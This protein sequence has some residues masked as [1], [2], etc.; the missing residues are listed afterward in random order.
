MNL[1]Y[2]QIVDVFT[3]DGLPSA[4]VRVGSALKHVSLAL[5]TAAIPGD[6]VLVCDGVAI[7]KVEN[8]RKESHVSGNPRQS[9]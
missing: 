6:T 1:L 2:A 4:K 8:A 3:E 7:G 5:D 9:P